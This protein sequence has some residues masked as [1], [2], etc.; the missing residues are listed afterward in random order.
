MEWPS[1]PWLIGTLLIAAVWFQRGSRRPSLRAYPGGRRRTRR[2]HLWR[3]V[4][5]YAALVTI[6]FALGSLDRLSD[7]LFSVHMAQHTLLMLVAAPLLALAAPWNAFWRPLPL[8]FRRAV[9]GGVA[10]SR[11][12]APGRRFVRWLA[13][14]I[15]VWLLFTAD[16]A[17]WHVPAAYDLTLSNPA[18]H[19]L[20]HLSFIVFGV[21][22]WAQ[23]VDS[24]PFRSRLDPFGRAAYAAAG[25]V[26]MWIL[27]VILELAAHPLYPAY[28]ALPHRPGGLNALNDQQLAGGV[29]L[30]PGS[31]PLAIVVFLGLYRW[32]DDENATEQGRPGRA[33]ARQRSLRAVERTF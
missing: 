12:L 20:E 22:F 28:A 18:V 24:P 3:G 1:D 11:T 5:F 30:G 2:D 19:Y 14:P 13:L 7:E 15:P 17:A 4:A 31:I 23:M 29:M 8:G 6:L 10:H 16:L 9:A 21:L 27:A 26:A 33:R 25:A 32:L